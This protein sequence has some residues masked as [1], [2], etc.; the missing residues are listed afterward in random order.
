MAGITLS[1]FLRR[2]SIFLLTIWIAAT[3]IFIIPRLAPGD[4]IAAMVSRMTQQ[5]GFV[6]NANEIIEG[7]RARFG[8]DDPILI[9]YGKYLASIFTWDF[10]YSLAGFPT[11]VKSMILRAL[12]WTIGLLTIAT[13][14]FFFIGN[15]LGALLAWKRTPWLVKLLIP[16]S[17]I[18]TSVPS[19]L[20]GLFLIYVFAFL[21]D[22]FPLIGAYGR[23]MS[24]NLSWEFVRS[25]IWHG[26]LPAFSIVIVTF[27]Y[28]VLGMRGMMITVEGE[29][30]MTLAEAKGLNPFYALYRYQIRNAILP[31]VTALALTI[32]GLVGGSILVE[33]IFSYRGM[34][35]I[36]FRAIR[37]QDYTVIQGTSFVLIVT[38]ALAVFI[39]DMIYPLIDPRISHEGR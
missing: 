33:F 13:A 28:W 24:P 32:G 4:P 25:V 23:G 3:I 36:I 5:A 12:P 9:Q 17:M 20:A 19:I 34:G 18:F 31:Q 30:Y 26:T 15:L 10:G 38:T 29:D 21:L 7:W 11:T 14:M 16:A 22:W 2:F 27:G 6:E 37:D 1:Y 39:M 8:L 35:N